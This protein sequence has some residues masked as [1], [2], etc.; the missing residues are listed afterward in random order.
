MILIWTL[1]S[2]SC[3]SHK[4]CA[5]SLPS[6]LRTPPKCLDGLVELGEWSSVR[7]Q[8]PFAGTCHH[9]LAMRMI[10]S[11]YERAWVC[12]PP[13]CPQRGRVLEGIKLC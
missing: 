5:I 9:P 12:D 2:L 13:H 10:P 7:K 4:N 6:C 8:H 11:L 1:R 3:G